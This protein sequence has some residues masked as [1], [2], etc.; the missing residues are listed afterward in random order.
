MNSFLFFLFKSTLILSLLYLA[1][2]L[3][4]RKETFFK[5]NRMVLIMMVLSSVLIPFIQSPQLIQ[6]FKKVNREPVFQSQPIV[7]ET[8][9]ATDDPTIVQAPIL[10]SEKVKTINWSLASILGIVYL[11]GV[12]VSILLLIYS[13]ILIMRLFNKARK[14]HQHGIH[15]MIVDNDV[16]AFSF[17][18]YILISQHDYDSNAEAIITHELSH[19]RLGHFYDLLLMELAKIIFWFNPLI[20]HMVNDLKEIHEF[21][22]DDHTLTSGID[23]TKYQLLIIQKCVGHQRFA[24]ANSF[25][26]CQIKNRITMM[27]KQKTSKAGLW[28]VA[29]FLP[30]LALLLMA[31]GKSGENA[32]PEKALLTPLVASATQD[33][34]KQWSEADFKVFT[35]K[36]R[37]EIFFNGKTLVIVQIDADSKITVDDEPITLDEIPGRIQKWLDYNFAEENERICFWK[38]TINGQAKMSPTSVITV[39]KDLNTPQEDYLKLLNAVANTVLKVRGDYS[40]EI[41]K[42][43]YTK[44][45]TDQRKKMDELIPMNV[46]VTNAELKKFELAPPPP[47]KS[48]N[49]E[50][51]KDGNYIN[52]RLFTIEEIRKKAEAYH[53]SNE[54]AVVSIK[55]EKEVPMERVTE[56]K[57]VLRNTKISNINLNT[58]TL[59]TYNSNAQPNLIIECK[60]DGIYLDEKR[61]TLEELRLKAREWKNQYPNGKVGLYE[62][63]GAQIPYT[64][65]IEVLYSEKIKTINTTL[66]SEDE[67][68]LF[69]YNDVTQNPVFSEGDFTKW[70][71]NEV[72][73]L[74]NKY[75]KYDFFGFS[76]SFVINENGEINKITVKGVGIDRKDINT[77][78]ETILTQMPSWSPVLHKGKPVKVKYT[79][80]NGMQITKQQKSGNQS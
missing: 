49:I 70:V 52:N 26:H 53:K 40:K 54:N 6:P 67:D 9:Q 50:M 8:I 75:N 61:C 62:S 48:F 11:G 72:N 71:S 69:T 73:K 16:S 7:E 64:K 15:L 59:K 66:R 55:V 12:L 30:L 25:N 35:K 29:T 56:I 22:A 23:A 24:L 41:F 38:K 68:N 18:R 34:V 47:L 77:E 17:G 45:T 5:L 42:S 28:K 3:L 57:E 1:F 27:N 60:S 10:I 31:F 46:G 2:S 37:E 78:F 43:P 19:I 39:K 4:M 33:S 74:H 14:T 44:L 63:K 36:T 51:R 79:R 32:P 20:Y 21:Q 58:N 13:I 76:Y 80:M 65:V